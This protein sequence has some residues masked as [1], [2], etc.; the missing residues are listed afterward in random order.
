MKRIILDIDDN[1]DSLL[2]IT[3]IGIGKEY[4]TGSAVYTTSKCI[5]LGNGAHIVIDKD[6]KMEQM[7]GTL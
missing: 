5:D 2:S 3:A 4:N 1:F 6:G 7:K